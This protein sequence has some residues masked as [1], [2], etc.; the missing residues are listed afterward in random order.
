MNG[1]IHRLSENMI[2]KIA[3]GEVIERPASVVKELVENSLD[4]QSKRVHVEIVDGGRQGIRVSD[5]GHGMGP[6]DVDVCAER[7]A[8]SKMRSPTDLFT[9]D[10][11]GFRGEALASVGAVSRMSLDTRPPDAEA[12]TQLVIEGGIRRAFGPIARDL[13]TTIEVRLTKDEWDALKT[14]RN[15]Q[16]K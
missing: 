5:D 4:A 9:I 8:T 13:G 1:R 2:R 7:H 3:A 6:E 15:L 16:F 12:G 14:R 10:T 11:L